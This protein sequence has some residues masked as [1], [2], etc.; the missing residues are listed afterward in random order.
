VNLIF[1]THLAANPA[2]ECQ[3]QNSTRN[4]MVASGPLILTFA[5][6]PAATG[7]KC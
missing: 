4:L 7:C 5:G 6:T 2:S 3:T 1:A